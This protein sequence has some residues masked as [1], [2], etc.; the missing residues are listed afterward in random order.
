MISDAE[1]ITDQIA[2]EITMYGPTHMCFSVGMGDHTRSMRSLEVLGA[3][4]I[5]ALEQRLGPL[6]AVGGS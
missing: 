1:K 5:P 2:N 3:E 6:D 4:I